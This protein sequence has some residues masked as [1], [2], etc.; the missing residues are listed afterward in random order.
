MQRKKTHG[1]DNGRRLTAIELT[2][3][4]GTGG[5]EEEDSGCYIRRHGKR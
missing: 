1:K 2:E 3:L 5:P 4:E